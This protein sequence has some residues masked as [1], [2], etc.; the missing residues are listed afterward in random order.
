MPQA[1]KN[2]MLLFLKEYSRVL[3]KRKFPDLLTFRYYK[4]WN[5]LKDKNPLSAKQP[6]ITFR[7]IDFITKNTHKTD[8]V[9]EY[10]G[11]GSTLYFLSQVSEVVTVEH[12]REWF[13]LLQNNI[14]PAD[15]P[16]W[17]G[18][19]I[20]PENSVDTT[21]L[22]K[23]QPT[24]YF[25]EDPKFRNNTFKSYSTFI[26]QF[27]DE[28]FDLV[29]IDGRAR[30]SCLFHAIPKVKIGGFLVLDNSE[31]KYYLKNNLKMLQ[32]HYRLLSDYMGPVPY[33]P[34]FSKTT[35]WQRIV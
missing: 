20:L 29:L 12:D 22:D 5:Y 3:V 10:G 8:K 14:D 33:S 2:Y 18:Q 34:H 25:S 9:F 1:S 27:K 35:I 7:A 32:K 16:R 26:C 21:N 24:D 28:F 30:T 6:W 23:S 19:L 31:R 11:G 17:N 13:H 15:A 4:K